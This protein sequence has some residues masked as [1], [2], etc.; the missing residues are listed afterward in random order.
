MRLPGNGV[1]PQCF[2][3]LTPELVTHPLQ[4]VRCSNQDQ[5]PGASLG[6]GKVLFPREVSGALEVTAELW[7]YRERQACIVHLV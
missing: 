1:L 5:Q 7:G 4:L 2:A 3:P 6:P